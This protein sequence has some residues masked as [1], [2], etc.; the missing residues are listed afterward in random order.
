MALYGTLHSQSY[1]PSRVTQQILLHFYKQH[2]PDTFVQK[3]HF[4]RILD[5]LANRSLKFEEGAKAIWSLG[6]DLISVSNLRRNGRNLKRHST[7]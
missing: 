1:G 2:H 7:K 3:I 5:G 6:G 4:G